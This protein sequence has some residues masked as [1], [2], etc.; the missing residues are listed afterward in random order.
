MVK[1]KLVE[2]KKGIAPDIRTGTASAPR[3]KV[4]LL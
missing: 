3:S 1:Y 4:E 2:N